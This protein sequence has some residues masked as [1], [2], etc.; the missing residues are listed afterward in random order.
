MVK[1][2]AEKGLENWVILKPGVPKK[3]HFSDHRFLERVITD[4]VFGV[5][6]RVQSL[7]LLVDEEDGHPVE[8]TLSIVSS[9]LVQELS[10]YLEGKKYKGYRFVIVK[11]AP[12]TVPPRIESIT[13][14]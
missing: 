14:I 9:K 6:K 11:D 12:G 4:P 1:G 8:K 3:L 13:P 2:V 7:M 10:G 5:E